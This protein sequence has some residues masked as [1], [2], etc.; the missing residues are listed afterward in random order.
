MQNKFYADGRFGLLVILQ[1][2]DT[3][4]KD[5]AIQNAFPNMNPVGIQ[6]TFFKKPLGEELEHDSRKNQNVIDALNKCITECK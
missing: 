5:G 6:V 4:E 3:A 1:G 2:V